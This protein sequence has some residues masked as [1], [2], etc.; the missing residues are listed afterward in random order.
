MTPESGFT[1]QIIFLLAKDRKIRI[2]IPPSLVH[3]AG[4]VG[5]LYQTS[6]DLE[7]TQYSSL[8]RLNVVCVTWSSL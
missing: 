1:V 6:P 4:D 8:H 3:G 2:N 5:I 7:K